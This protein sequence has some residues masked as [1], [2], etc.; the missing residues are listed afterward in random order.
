MASVSHQLWNSSRPNVISV[1]LRELD[2][3]VKIFGFLPLESCLTC[4]VSPVFR[5]RG[6]SVAPVDNA[7]MGRLMIAFAAINPEIC[8]TPIVSRGQG[9][10]CAA[11][12]ARPKTRQRG[13]FAPNAA[14]LCRFP[15]QLVAL[16]T[17]PLQG[18]AWAAAGLS[19]R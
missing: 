6:G 17:R 2:R 10:K 5:R 14:R 8:S 9:S 4:G 7:A 3:R 13:A 18:S 19:E 16:R 15:A 1:L 12:V 11:Q